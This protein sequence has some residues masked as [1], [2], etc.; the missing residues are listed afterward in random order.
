LNINVQKRNFFRFLD[1]LNLGLSGTVIVGVDF[2]V[3]DKLLLSNH[4]FELFSGDKEVVLSVH[5]SLSRLSSGVADTK[6]ETIGVLGFDSVNQRAF[7]STTWANDDKRL[8]KFVLVCSASL[9][10]V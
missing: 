1:L 9:L 4:Y 5:F 3:L 10:K 8:I 6:S 2:K 7:T